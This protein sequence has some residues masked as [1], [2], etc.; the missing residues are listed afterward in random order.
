MIESFNPN[1]LLTDDE[2]ELIQNKS[3]YSSDF[4]EVLHAIETKYNLTWNLET[5]EYEQR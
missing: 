3:I 2:K 4:A 1:L 5:K